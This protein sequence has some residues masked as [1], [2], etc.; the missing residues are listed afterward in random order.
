MAHFAV[1][2]DAFKSCL[3]SWQVWLIQFVV[4]LLLFG[5]FTA[6]LLLPVANG[7]FLVLNILLALLLLLAALVL[8]GGTL[9]YFYSQGRNEGASLKDVFGRALRNFLAVAICASAAFLLWIVVGKADAFHET[10]PA[11]LRSMTPMFLRKHAGLPIFQGFFETI[12]FVLRWI[13]V[14]GLLL[15][16][17]S[18]ASR[19]GFRGFGQQGLMTWKKTVRSISY[20]WV[21]ILSAL[22]G[23]LATEK[24]MG[25]TPDFRTSTFTGETVSL[26]LRA[27]FSY[28]L[29]LFA[30]LLACSV[31]GREGGDFHG[32]SEDTGRQAFA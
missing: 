15:P 4:N 29:G 18:S 2:A 24:I 19:L 30:W 28:L 26:V 21:V 23:V 3:R 17:L 32:D 20:W 5:L 27:L 13:L 16:F 6:W 11:Y 22:L 25:W 10:I 12:F 8:H 1:A 7:G 31:V 14:P 9:N